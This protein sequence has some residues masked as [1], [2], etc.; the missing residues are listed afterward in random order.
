MRVAWLSTQLPP[1]LKM[2]DCWLVTIVRFDKI[3]LPDL[4]GIRLTCS[5]RMCVMSV[6]RSSNKAPMLNLKLPSGRIVHLNSLPTNLSLPRA[7]CLFSKI[8]ALI[9]CTSSIASIFTWKSTNLLTSSCLSS[10]KTTDASPYNSR[11]LSSPVRIPPVF[12]MLYFSKE[13][14]PRLTGSLEPFLSGTPAVRILRGFYSRN[15]KCG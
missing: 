6:A 2:L 8:H 13:P 11:L 14:S 10:S 15:G 1:S 7:S 4:D 3:V 9:W 12:V 5:K